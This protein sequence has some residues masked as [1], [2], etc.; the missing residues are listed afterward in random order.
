M[1]LGLALVLGIYHCYY[2]LSN[3][4]FKKDFLMKF[5]ESAAL[6]SEYHSRV[7]ALTTCT[8]ITLTACF[9]HVPNIA[10]MSSIW[11]RFSI[12]N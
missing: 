1:T 3:F 10:P 7:L 12:S 11:T 4:C 9:Y 2:R 8:L 5:T 6:C